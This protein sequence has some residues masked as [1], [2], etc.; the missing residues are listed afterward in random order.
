MN[1][2]NCNITEIARVA[3]DS[4]KGISG[5][6][7]LFNRPKTHEKMKN[8]IVVD[9]PNRI[10]NNIANGQTNCVIEVYV[11]DKNG[12]PDMPAI[13]AL[14]EQIYSR[15]PISHELCMIC[16]PVSQMGGPDNFG[17]YCLLIYC[18]VIINN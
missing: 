18:K 2:A 15:L 1:L 6:L 5:N 13:S 8:F 12:V 4:L 14:Q 11:K 9:F 17:F 10:Y 7:F 16:N 3:Y